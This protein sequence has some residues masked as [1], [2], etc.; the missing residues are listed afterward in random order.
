MTSE[1]DVTYI[2]GYDGRNDEGLK[3]AILR[4]AAREISENQDET[5]GINAGEVT[6]RPQ[7][8]ILGWTT[9]EL[10]QWD[11]LRRRVVV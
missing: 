10:R 3:V 7:P 9:E 4:V 2:G 5:V 8:N 6:G 1:F 11:H